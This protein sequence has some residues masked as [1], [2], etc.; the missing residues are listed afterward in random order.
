MSRQATPS[1]YQ[2]RPER[3]TRRPAH[4]ECTSATFLGSAEGLGSAVSISLCGANLFKSLNWKEKAANCRGELS[5]GRV[6]AAFWPL[7]SNF[8]ME[9]ADCKFAGFTPSVV[10]IHS[11]PS[12]SPEPFF[13]C[14]SRLASNWAFHLQ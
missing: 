4:V 13:K 5:Q 1:A 9:R 6:L 12:L 14:L 11:Y 7:K 8:P 10:R 2:R 3:E